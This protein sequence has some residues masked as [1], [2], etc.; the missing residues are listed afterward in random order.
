MNPEVGT[1]YLA[2][3]LPIICV[4]SI[5]FFCKRRQYPLEGRFP[6][7]VV[8]CNALIALLV[9]NWGA[10]FLVGRDYPCVLLDWVS[11]ISLTSLLLLLLLRA[12]LL[13]LQFELAQTVDGA[14]ALLR[15]SPSREVSVFGRGSRRESFHASQVQ[16][17]QL[18]VRPPSVAGGSA[19][20]PLQPTTPRHVDRRRRSRASLPASRAPAA[21]ANW[22]LQHRWLARRRFLTALFCAHVAYWALS[23]GLWLAFGQV[24]EG[25]LAGD[26]KKATHVTFGFGVV[27][28]LTISVL[29]ARV[30]WRLRLHGTDSFGV[31]AEVRL[32][33]KRLALCSSC[34][35]ADRSLCSSRL[36]RWAPW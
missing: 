2:V 15:A 6:R 30:G 5:V 18:T 20:F 21:P 14:H 7:V 24:G 4:A 10:H 33:R 31:K 27:E 8:C 22:W 3:L 1:A 9:S 35:L 36:W 19:V 11:A 29:L 32:L 26:N 13:L 28:G 16:Q 25:C 34:A 23:C 12:M 17:Q